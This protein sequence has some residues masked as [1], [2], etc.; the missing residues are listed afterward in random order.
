MMDHGLYS[1]APTDAS[2]ET[3]NRKKR[4]LTLLANSRTRRKLG[5]RFE[6]ERM[7]ITDQAIDQVISFGK[8]YAFMKAK[9]HFGFEMNIP[10][11]NEAYEEI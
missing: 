7:S 5:S 6:R 10:P 1:P 4:I 2:E 8:D 9:D 11:A 3:A